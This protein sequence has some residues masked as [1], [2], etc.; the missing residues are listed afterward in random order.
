MSDGRLGAGAW[1]GGARERSSLIPIDRSL[2]WSIR[3]GKSATKRKLKL[4]ERAHAT[5]CGP[6]R[7]WSDGTFS[8]NC[9]LVHG[10]PSNLHMHGYSTPVRRMV[11]Y[12]LAQKGNLM[13][14]RTP[15]TTPHS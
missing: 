5:A 13:A 3:D 2:I 15:R 4:D 12:N 7:A 6:Q 8:P 11:P 9:S 10:Q 14:D 1:V